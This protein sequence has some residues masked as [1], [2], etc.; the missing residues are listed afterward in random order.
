MITSSST[1]RR[2]SRP[3][4]R[5]DFCN[6]NPGIK[7]E[8]W[9]NP[10]L[11]SSS[12]TFTIISYSYIIILLLDNVPVFVPVFWFG[13]RERSSKLSNKKTRNPLKQR[14]PGHGADSQIRT[15]DLILTKHLKTKPRGFS[16]WCHVRIPPNN[17]LILIREKRSHKPCEALFYWLFRF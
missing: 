3:T 7:N 2:H 16:F 17:G 1:S 15:G 11:L 6:Y 5:Q 9:S 10:Y 13:V 12:S 4:G 14:A 8:T